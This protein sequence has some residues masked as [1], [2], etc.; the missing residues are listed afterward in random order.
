MTAVQLTIRDEAANLLVLAAGGEL[1]R[2]R[3]GALSAVAR[4]RPRL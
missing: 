2:P 1:Y 4:D 3:R